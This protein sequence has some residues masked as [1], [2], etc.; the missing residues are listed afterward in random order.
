M[1]PFKQA[2]DDVKSREASFCV[3]VVVV[4]GFV[5]SDSKIPRNLCQKKGL[6]KGCIYR[7]RPRCVCVRV[8]ELKAIIVNILCQAQT[9]RNE[10]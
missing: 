8:C 5:V 7:Y 9:I 10:L 6:I 3:N 1:G 2:D 4:V